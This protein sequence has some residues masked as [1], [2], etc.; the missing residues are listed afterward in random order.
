MELQ[1]VADAE[2]KKGLST[3]AKIAI[4]GAAGYAIGRALGKKLA[5]H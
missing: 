2:K 4:G 1:G 5:Q 3:A